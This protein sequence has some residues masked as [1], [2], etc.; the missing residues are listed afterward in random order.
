MNA[1][2]ADLTAF[3]GSAWI[4][5]ALLI[6]QNVLKE[7]HATWKQT[8]VLSVGVKIKMIYKDIVKQM[9]ILSLWVHYL[10]YAQVVV[11]NLQIASVY[12]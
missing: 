3:V 2:Q 5:S 12:L 1:L 9:M 7:G 6:V 11:A 8:P 10:M 4:M